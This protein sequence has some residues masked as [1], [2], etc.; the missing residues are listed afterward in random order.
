VKV[1]LVFGTRPEAIKM[2]PVIRAARTSPY[3]DVRVCVTGQHRELLDQVL[4]FFCIC[5]DHDLDVMHHNQD[6]NSLATRILAGLR[7]VLMAECP[8]LV[9]V[10]GDTLSAFAAALA[11]FFE[12]IPV[13]HIEAGLRTYDLASPFPEEA[14]RQLITRLSSIHFAPTQANADSLM[15]EGIL[16]RS[17]HVTGNPGIDAVLWTRE[18]VR[19]RRVNPLAAHLSISQIRQVD[20]SK[21]VVIVTTHRRENFGP[22]VRELCQAVRQIASDHPEAALVFPVHPNPQ[23]Q[24]P[25]HAALRTCR[26]VFLL[27][28]LDYPS[29]VQLMDSSS[30]V[31][32]DSGGIQEEA[33]ALGTPLIVTRLTTERM[34]A[35]A[36][37]ASS[38]TGTDVDSVVEAA[39]RILRKPRA[40]RPFRGSSSP[41][42]DGC[43]ANKIVQ[44]I[45][46]LTFV[47]DQATAS[48]QALIGALGYAKQPAVAE[49]APAR[50]LALC[51]PGTETLPTSCF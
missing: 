48:L 50:N 34:E 46:E 12:R 36:A 26:N 18:R 49:T 1:L 20:E 44:T 5:P 29:F 33:T 2:A 30:L 23:V 22:G 15:K 11:A 42:G 19:N 35:V 41:Y 28:P 25:V 47:E 43:A 8:D 14:M 9:L 13:G 27:S 37:G 17:I 21:H 16:P 7:P 32:T 24:E 40:L 51:T 39:D 31:I 6:L 4:N 3:V 10:Q 45:E 38:L